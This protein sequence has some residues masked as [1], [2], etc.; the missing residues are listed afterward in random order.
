MKKRWRGGLE[1]ISDGS[2]RLWE[3]AKIYQ[4]W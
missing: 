2:K 3:G 4:E 1:T